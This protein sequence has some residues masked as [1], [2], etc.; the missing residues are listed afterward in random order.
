MSQTQEKERY[1][2]NTPGD[3]YVENE[4]CLTCSVW[5]AIVPD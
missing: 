2:L 3:F 4:R 5:E 1:P